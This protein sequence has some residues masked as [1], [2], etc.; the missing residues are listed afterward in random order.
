MKL[1]IGILFAVVLW[2]VLLAFPCSAYFIDRND[3]GELLHF[4][5]SPGSVTP[6]ID[7]VISDDEYM[8]FP[9]DY[10]NDISLAVPDEAMLDD[11]DFEANTLRLSYDEK[12]VYIAA[13]TSAA[14]FHNGCDDNPGNMWGQHCLQVS[15]ADVHDDDASMRLE[16]GYGLSSDT[17]ALLFVNWADGQRIGYEAEPGRDFV[18]V[19]NGGRLIYELRIP[20]GAFQM[21]KARAGG[22]IRLCVVWA[23]GT[24]EDDLTDEYRHVQLAY[25]CTGDPGKDVTGHAVIH[26]TEKPGDLNGDGSVDI[27]DASL[28]LQH[29]IFPE[30]Y[31]VSYSKSLDFD[32]D[33]SIDIRDA[34]RLL[35]YSMYPEDY[36]IEEPETPEEPDGLAFTSNG[37][38][39]CYVSGIGTCTD[40]EIVIPETS[41]TGDRVTGIG[42]YAFQ[43]CS[44]LTSVSIPESVTDI[45]TGAFLYC[46]ALTSV[47]LP[48]GITT[49]APGTFFWCTSLQS[50]AIPEKVTAINNNAFTY[51][52]S[53][54]SVTI[55]ES[56]T[57][58]DF[59]VFEDCSS[60]ESIYYSGTQAQWDAISKGD[61]WDTFTGSY[62][63]HCAEDAEYSLGLVY[64]SNSDGTCYVSGIGTCTDTDIVIPE[65][66]PNEDRVTSIGNN[67]FLYCSSLTSITIPDSVTSIGN[68]AFS[69]CSSLTSITIPDSVTSIGNYAFYGCS[70]LTS[71][72]IPDS[73][74]SIGS[75][76]FQRCSFLTSVTIGNSVTSIG[77]SAFD[78]CSSLS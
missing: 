51:C 6:T 74:T 45:G 47:D 40:T 61:G 63:V 34:V 26:L 27:Y 77:I 76:A 12:Y 31:P 68:D 35:R 53:L 54:T 20:Y 48:S 15:L 43:N 42:E 5:V 65:T 33:G 56:V 11:I 60:L 36:P 18:V 4:Y 21:K 50:V 7:G 38:G 29:S 64:T 67:A 66:S 9:I 30:L 1:R 52:L 23:T 16:V 41:P 44:S 78:G 14:D 55:P 70:S 28:L 69:G 19:N 22:A 59:G 25:G 2:C 32:R 37:D 39:T 8:P 62:A 49:I 71:V 24:S 75:G 17:G 73:V 10:N 58:I 13:T 57:F 46:S 3:S 72:N